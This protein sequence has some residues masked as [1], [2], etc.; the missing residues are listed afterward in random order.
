MVNIPSLFSPTFCYFF[1]SISGLAWLFCFH[2]E[3]FLLIKILN[4][5]V[6]TELI[7]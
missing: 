6:S 7:P 3:S 5:V 2:R 4:E 1:V